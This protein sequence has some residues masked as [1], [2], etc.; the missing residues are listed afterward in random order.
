MEKILNLFN[1][2]EK[3]VLAFSGGNDSFALAY[4]LRDFFKNFKIVYVSTPFHSKNMER[5]AEN[6][7]KY[8]NLYLNKIK[9]NTFYSEI[10][11]NSINRC[12][13]CKKEIFSSIKRKFE[14][15]KILDGSNFSDTFEYRPGLKANQELG[16]IS[17][18]IEL[19]ISKDNI[20]NFLKRK[21]LN[22]LISYPTTCLA[23]RVKYNI[24]ITEEILHKI[25]YVENIL[26]ENGITFSRFRVLDNNKY[27]IELLAEDIHNLSKELLNKIKKEVNEDDIDIRE[28]KKGVFDNL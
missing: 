25:K 12:Y 5:F 13:Y 9:I 18:F 1:K 11:K 2:E 7:A 8:L 3:L 15:Y 19:K 16:I 14:N 27:F 17:P 24:E 21:K 10:L 23:T 26:M 22:K 20:I 28:Y 6:R 4:I